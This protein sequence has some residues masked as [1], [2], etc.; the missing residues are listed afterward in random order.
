MATEWYRKETWSVSDKADFEA[1]LK[2]SRTVFH[3]SQ[4]LCIQAYHLVSAK[5]PLYSAALDLVDRVFNEFRVDS[6]M[7]KPYLIKAQCIL[8][9]QGFSAAVPYYREG[10]K[11]ELKYP[12]LRT[13]AW[14]DFSWEIV[15]ACRTDL[16]DEALALIQKPP[17]PL[18][19]PAAVYKMNLIQAIVANQKC[20]HEVAKQFA[21]TAWA[22]SKCETSGLPYHKD[23]GLVSKQ[24]KWAEATLKKIL[25][26]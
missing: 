8:E 13:T 4:Y 23:I 21:Q 18:L 12:N 22:A 20:E 10:L 7:A 14:L 19:L 1:H 17:Y 5:P 9:L 3:K 2:R 6:Q 11:F 24:E 16:Y 26:A 15:K 25:N